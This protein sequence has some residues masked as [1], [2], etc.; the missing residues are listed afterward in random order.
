M[1]TPA[2]PKASFRSQM[3]LARERAIIQAVNR[4]LAEKGFEAMTVDQATHFLMENCYYEE[5]AARPE[6]M[7]G[8][9]DP[10]YCFY[11]LGKLQLLKLRRDWQSQEGAAFTLKRFHD[12]VLSH[13]SPQIRTLRELM[14][15][16]PKSW[17]QI[18]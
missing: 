18:L 3:L 4:L 10:G 2:T 12:E 13:G 16:D 7:R 17:P 11:T 1:V 15:R 8:S 9:F 6:A 5:K 14:L